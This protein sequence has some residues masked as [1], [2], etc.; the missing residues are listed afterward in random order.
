MLLVLQVL[1]EDSAFIRVTKGVFTLRCWAAE[2][3]PQQD[4]GAAGASGGAKVRTNSNP[5]TF[6]RFSSCLCGR[7]SAGKP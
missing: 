4:Q 3:P 5:S 1:R 2:L 7:V 6:T